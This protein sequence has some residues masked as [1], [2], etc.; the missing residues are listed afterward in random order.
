MSP[1]PQVKGVPI[2]PERGHSLNSTEALSLA[3]RCLM[4]GHAFSPGRSDKVYPLPLTMKYSG[5]ARINGIY[6]SGLLAPGSVIE[7]SGS[8]KRVSTS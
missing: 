2:P 8:T 3:I 1:Q 4:A 5:D 7:G 6:R